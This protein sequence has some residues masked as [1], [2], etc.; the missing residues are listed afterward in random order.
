MAR[1]RSV[2]ALASVGVT[3]FGMTT[4]VKVLQDATWQIRHSKYVVPT[5]ARLLA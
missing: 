1:G 2:A 5:S 3:S 4:L